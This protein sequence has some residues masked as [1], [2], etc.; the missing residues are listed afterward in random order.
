MRDGAEGSSSRRVAARGHSGG[1]DGSG[2]EAHPASRNLHELAVAAA[3]R[4]GGQT[5]ARLGFRAEVAAL[6]LCP[7]THEDL[8]GARQ[9]VRA[10]LARDAARSGLVEAPVEKLLIVRLRHAGQ[11]RAERHDENDEDDREPHARSLRSARARAIS[12]AP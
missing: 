4:R 10:V 1:E 7:T 3:C 12:R 8:V 9:A 2:R 5:A 11:P 6:A